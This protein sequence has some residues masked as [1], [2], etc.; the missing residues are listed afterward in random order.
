MFW[1]LTWWGRVGR[2]GVAAGVVPQGVGVVRKRV[3]GRAATVLSGGGGGRRLQ[4]RALV[5]VVVRHPGGVGRVVP[6]LGGEGALVGA[7]HAG[8]VSR[9]VLVLV[10][11]PE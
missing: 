8:R 9:T 6:R 2:S 3:H 10:G 1:F 4:V 7:T 5:D 11:R